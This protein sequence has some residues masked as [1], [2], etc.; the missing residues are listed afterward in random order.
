MESAAIRERAWDVMWSMYD[1][2][3]EPHPHD[4]FEELGEQDAVNFM[5]HMVLHARLLEGKVTGK[6]A[7]FFSVRGRNSKPMNPLKHS[8]VL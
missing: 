4:N 5:Y 1:R 6:C 7:L 2:D 3:G 8:Y